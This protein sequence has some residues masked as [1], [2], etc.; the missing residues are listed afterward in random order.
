M[1]RMLHLAVL[2]TA[3]CMANAQG[4]FEAVWDYSAAAAGAVAGTAGWTFT[5]QSTIKVTD[6]GFLDDLTSQGPVQIGLWDD[7]GALLAQAVVTATNVMGNIT[8]YQS[9][10]PVLLAGGSVYTIGAYNPNG[11]VFL[12]F[13]DFGTNSMDTVTPD[14]SNPDPDLI[15][16]NAAAE[17][18]P[19]HAN[20][21]KPTLLFPNGLDLGANFRFQKAVPEPATWTLLGLGGLAVVA[22]R[23]SRR[24]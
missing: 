14:P 22:Y 4:T 19:A 5:P 10:T 17:Q 8:R 15:Q 20:F 11:N 6:L 18:D 2:G 9:I 1:K 7:Q 24:R 16:F 21:G 13:V 3:I 23:R 12:H